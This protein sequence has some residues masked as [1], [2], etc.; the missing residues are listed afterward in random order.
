MPHFGAI[1]TLRDTRDTPTTQNEELRHSADKVRTSRSQ[2]H[3]ALRDFSAHS[4][5]FLLNGTRSISTPSVGHGKFPTMEPTTAK[6]GFNPN[7]L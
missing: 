1:A 7:Q 6:I 4:R 3:H 2:A 5:D